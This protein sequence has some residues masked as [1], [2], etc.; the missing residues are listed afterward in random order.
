M[1]LKKEDGLSLLLL[2]FKKNLCQKCMIKR[3]FLKAAMLDRRLQDNWFTYFGYA[4]VYKKGIGDTVEE[5]KAALGEFEPI[6]K[7]AFSAWNELL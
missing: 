4:A 6:E 1:K 5:I 2:I 7:T 3:I